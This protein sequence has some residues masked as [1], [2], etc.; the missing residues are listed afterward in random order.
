MVAACSAQLYAKLRSSR[1]G[2]LLRVK[3]GQQPAT[4]CFRENSLRLLACESA[5]V[6]KHV[7]EFCQILRGHLGQHLF[8]DEGGIELCS[9]SFSTKFFRHH[10]SAEES[11][12]DVNRLLLA[13]FH[14]QLQNV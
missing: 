12:D 5:P 4:F 3:P 9:I 2:Q 10:M 8:R 14:L 6:A 7:A 11:R 13:H 1:P